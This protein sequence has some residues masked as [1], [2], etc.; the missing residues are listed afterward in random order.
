MTRFAGLPDRNT[1]PS[2]GARFASLPDE[3]ASMRQPARIDHIRAVW[4]NHCSESSIDSAHHRDE[5]ARLGTTKA[6]TAKP[7]AAAP[8]RI[9]PTVATPSKP[10]ASA[11]PKPLPLSIPADVAAQGPEAVAAYES[12]YLRAK[13]RAEELSKH[14]AVA[15]RSAEAM[16]LFSQGKSNSEII[17]ALSAD[18]RAKAADAV[19]AKARASIDGQRGSAA[20]APAEPTNQPASARKLTAAEM[21]ADAVW[22]RARASLDGNRPLAAAD[23]EPAAA[24]KRGSPDD[25]WTRAYAAAAR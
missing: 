15:G 8:K 24:A 1:A 17:S 25:I 9:A 12:G 2:P 23:E 5:M 7:T 18:Q 4:A 19:W 22:D 3:L 11:P 20:S 21:K 14:P 10:T 16:Q 13:S 6:T